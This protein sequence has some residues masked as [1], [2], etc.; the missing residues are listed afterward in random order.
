MIV[1]NALYMLTAVLWST[2][3]FEFW[4]RKE[5]KRAIEWG[6][7]D[8][9]EDE[10]MRPT[11]QGVRRRSPADDSMND[12][13]FSSNRRR[14]RQAIGYLISLVILCIVIGVVAAI[15][16]LRYWLMKKYSYD[17]TSLFYKSIPS[18]CSTI[19]AIQIVIFNMLYNN[20]ALW[21]TKWENHRTQSEFESAL[22][23]KT[24]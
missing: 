13:W 20:I 19:N 3:F 6:Q 12:I 17:T 18:I 24:L 15:L 8:F 7:M 5:N 22:I 10:V 14:F 16:Y 1:F 2:C 4:K 23:S 21:L 11:F 9:E